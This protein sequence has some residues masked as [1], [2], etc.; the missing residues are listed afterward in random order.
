MAKPLVPDDLWALVGPLVP[1]LP[2]LPRAG[3]SRVP[4]R[5]ALTGIIFALKTGI[6]WEMLPQECAVAAG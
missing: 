4:N 3:R 2:P 5:Q 1:D 6:Q